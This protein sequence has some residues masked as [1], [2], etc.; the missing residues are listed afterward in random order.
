MLGLVAL[1]I[2]RYAS[3][4]AND[5]PDSGLEAQE[6]IVVRAAEGV[7]QH[8][9]GASPDATPSENANNT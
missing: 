1:V 8:P 7:L 4:G 9:L 2:V 3:K 5:K 6:P